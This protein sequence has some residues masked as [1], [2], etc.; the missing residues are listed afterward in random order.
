VLAAN[1]TVEA[2]PASVGRLTMAMT[3]R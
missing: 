1:I 3:A 2:I